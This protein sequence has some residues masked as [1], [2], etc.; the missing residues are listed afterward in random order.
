MVIVSSI[1]T[2]AWAGTLGILEP[3]QIDQIGA[4][5]ETLTG[6]F[7]EVHP[8]DPHLDPI[9]GGS[10]VGNGRPNIV[11]LAGLN[12]DTGETYVFCSGSQISDEW[13]LTAAHCVLAVGYVAPLTPYVLYGGSVLTNGYTDAVPWEGYF[14]N[15]LYDAYAFTNDAG[16][17]HMDEAR[18]DVPWMVLNDAPPDKSWLGTLLTFYGYGIT[19]DGAQ[20]AGTLR[21]TQ[22]PITGVDG[23]NLSTFA[24]GT[25]VCSGDSGGPSTFAGPDGPEQAGI[26]AFVTPGCVGGSAGSTRVDTQLGFIAGH[27]P[28]FATS[29]ADLPHDGPTGGGDGPSRDWL[30]LGAEDGVPGFD[31]PGDGV[32]ATGCATPPRAPSA[33]GGAL[34]LLVALAARRRQLT[35]VAA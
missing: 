7:V 31:I 19:T 18:P 3:A 26:N 35:T 6:L 10:T 30:D 16:L 14:S 4:D 2:A 24:A 12:P 34:A 29:Y 25:N 32:S 13:I 11:A 23:Y 27:V 21:T 8:A 17:V 5:V 15:P 28:E 22:I 20:D 33:M 9:V 1:V